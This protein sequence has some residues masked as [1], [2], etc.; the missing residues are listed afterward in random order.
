M[1]SLAEAGFFYS[2]RR[3]TT[4][5]ATNYSSGRQISDWSNIKTLDPPT[6]ESKPDM[7][8]VQSKTS[9]SCF[10]EFVFIASTLLFRIASFAM[11][12]WVFIVRTQ[13]F[14]AVFLQN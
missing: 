1:S 10:A 4:G 11:L 13:L 7:S 8:S 3:L 6:E 2:C 12:L 5:E 14:C 9:V